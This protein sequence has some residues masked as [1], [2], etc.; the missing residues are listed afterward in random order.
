MGADR[1]ELRVTAVL[2]EV[3]GLRRGEQR[4]D[5]AAGGARERVVAAVV[6]GAAGETVVRRAAGLA[7]RLGGADLVAV[8]IVGSRG[9]SDAS[10]SALAAQRALVESLGGTYHSVI[11]DDVPSALLD[12]ARAQNATQL[13]IGTDLRARFGSVL[14]GGEIGATVLRGAGEIDVQLVPYDRSV[15]DRR[16]PP[17][18]GGLSRRR[19]LAGFAAALVLPAA[20]VVLSFTSHG[21]LDL[22]E[23]MLVLLAVVA[24]ALIGGLWPALSAAVV[25]SLLLNYFFTPPLYTLAVAELDDL[26]ALAVFVAVAVMV[27]SVVDLAA[28]RSRQAARA[29]AEAEML[30]VL[31]KSVLRGEQA[32]PALLE[33]VRDAF[34]LR[35]ATLLRRPG[36]GDGWE[37][38]DSTGPGPGG[39]LQD[40]EVEVPVLEDVRL[41]LRGRPLPPE[42]RR[43]L[44]AF[45]THLAA[46]LDRGR[47]A[48]AAAEVEPI[49]A[50]DRMRTALLAA[51]SHDL[52]TPIAAAKAAVTSLRST[53]VAWDAQDREELLATAEQ[54]LDRLTRLV[55]NLLDLSR[56][57]AGVLSVFPRPV[58]LDEILPAA[59]R[60]SGA[61]AAVEAAGLDGLPPVLADPVLLERVVVNLLANAARY[62]PAGK[63]VVLDGRVLDGWVEF[64]VIDRGP[65]IPTQDQQRV[66]QPFQRLGDRTAGS[67]IGLG[68]ALS[69]GLTEAMTGSLR[70]EDTPGGGLTMVLSL[71]AA[72]P[73]TGAAPPSTG[74]APPSTGAAAADGFRPDAT[75]Q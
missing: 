30:W 52:R 3:D 45:A 74:A 61:E 1:G 38:V 36:T 41:V 42:D 14:S 67:G 75:P 64:R 51:V 25:G 48:R 43:V 24:V 8:H 72:P 19:R 12:F 49:A 22:S 65:G 35:S 39:T 4:A 27:S 57:Q 16:L 44:A 56:L 32:V 46:A 26:V 69:R 66:F 7:A 70:M 15:A 6:R 18:G 2:E 50:A 68:L 59:L 23:V 28:R 40:G 10:S 58:G 54:S 17:V 9:L 37:V 31:A 53:D 34:S 5:P 47:L 21:V 60:E 73:S 20:L 29:S 13:V 71:P 11:G 55:D 63:P 62:S 33:R